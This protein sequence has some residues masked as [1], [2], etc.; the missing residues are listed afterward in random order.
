M[1]DRLISLNVMLDAID[2]N[3]GILYD[4]PTL[5]TSLKKMVNELPTVDAVPVVHG[6]WIIHEWAEEV[7]NMLIPNYECSVCGTWKRD[8]TAFCPHCGADM[9]KDGDGN[10]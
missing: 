1:D 7:D 8:D 6:H 2:A 5:V 10:G 9:R 3:N 4:S